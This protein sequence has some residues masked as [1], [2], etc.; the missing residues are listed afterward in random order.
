VIFLGDFSFWKNVLKK[1]SC[2]HDNYF[3]YFIFGKYI[4]FVSK[5]RGFCMHV[6]SSL[7]KKLLHTMHRGRRSGSKSVCVCGGGGGGSAHSA[8][9]RRVAS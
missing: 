2:Y 6:F 4:V 7:T 8:R 3:K 5:A 1:L 9:R